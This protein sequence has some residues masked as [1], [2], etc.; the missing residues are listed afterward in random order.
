MSNSYARIMGLEEAQKAETF[1]VDVFE[2]LGEMGEIVGSRK[3]VAKP[4]WMPMPFVIHDDHDHHYSFEI[5]RTWDSGRS[6]SVL[7]MS[8]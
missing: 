4:N 1:R 7:S 6:H 3:L 2:R 8:V 5:L